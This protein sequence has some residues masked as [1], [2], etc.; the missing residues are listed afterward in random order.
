MVVYF[1]IIS[2]QIVRMLQCLKWL[3]GLVVSIHHR[4]PM[5][6]NHGVLFQ[7]QILKFEVVWSAMSDLHTRRDLLGNFWIDITKYCPYST[8]VFFRF[9]IMWKIM[10]TKLIV[11]QLLNLLTGYFSQHMQTHINDVWLANSQQC[12]KTPLIIYSVFNII[13]PVHLYAWSTYLYTNT[14]SNIH[15]HTNIY[16]SQL[17]AAKKIM[18]ES[19]K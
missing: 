13:A 2:Q 18:M 16:Q 9:C 19:K 7:I 3:H 11:N 17:W 8:N 12:F 6:S 1:S 5:K 15:T 14:S 4:K 10:I